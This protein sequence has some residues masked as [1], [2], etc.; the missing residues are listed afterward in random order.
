MTRGSVVLA[1]KSLGMKR[2]TP[3]FM[4]AL[5]K[6]LWG[7]TSPIMGTRLMTA[8]WPLKAVMSWS[9]G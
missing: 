9:S 6:A 4:A 1:P 3:A 2:F 7:P 5:M 8:S